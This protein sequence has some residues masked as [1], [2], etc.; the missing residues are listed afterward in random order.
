M[1][2]KTAAALILKSLSC[3]LES[4]GGDPREVYTEETG[5]DLVEDVSLLLPL[6]PHLL[7][8]L[9]LQHI[10]VWQ[11]G[12]VDWN[13]PST[14]WQPPLQHNEKLTF[15]KKFW[16]IILWLFTILRQPLNPIS[17]LRQQQVKQ[18]GQPGTGRMR[19]GGTRRRH[20]KHQKA[21][22]GT[23]RRQGLQ[24]K[25]RRR[26]GWMALLRSKSWWAVQSVQAAIIHKVRSQPTL[27]WQ[28]WL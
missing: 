19:L 7:P 2:Q 20:Q 6:H 9:L 5:G 11:G 23:R 3:I 15:A 10:K 18:G 25:S 4:R 21:R 8:Q 26:Q 24:W 14:D 28:I 27:D 1:L 13:Q 16:L 17:L 22:E 12:G